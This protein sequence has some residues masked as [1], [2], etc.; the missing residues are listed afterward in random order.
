MLE[1]LLMTPFSDAEPL[2]PQIDQLRLT[3]RNLETAGSAMAEKYLAGIIIM[4]LPE[5]LSALK[6][7]LANTDD[8]KL[9]VEGTTNQVLADEARRVRASG[10]RDA[11]AF[12]AKAKSTGRRSRK[13]QKDDNGSGSGNSNNGSTGNNKRRGHEVPD[14]WTLKREK[15]EKE[16]ANAT[17]TTDSSKTADTTAKASIARVSLHDDVVTSS[18]PQQSKSLGPNAPA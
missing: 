17:F 10:E 13:K 2:E 8:A 14:C 18:G 9:T 5:S 15:E 1:R 6:T 12:F 3:A 11:T 7:I 16:K 4:R